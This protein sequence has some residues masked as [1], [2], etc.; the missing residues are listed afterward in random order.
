M[1][2]FLVLVLAIQATITFSAIPRDGGTYKIVSKFFGLV[3]GNAGNSEVAAQPDFGSDS[4][5]WIMHQ[6]IPNVFFI[7]NKGNGQYLS[8]ASAPPGLAPFDPSTFEQDYQLLPV[9]V[10][11]MIKPVRNPT[12]VMTIAPD[13]SPSWQ[14][15]VGPTPADNQ[16]F[17]FI[18]SR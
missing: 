2:L 13:G 6:Q 5:K 8:N 3:L 16:L 9:G 12:S 18:C 1:K 4:Q 11:Y 17:S 15:P 14:P 10:Y 7:E